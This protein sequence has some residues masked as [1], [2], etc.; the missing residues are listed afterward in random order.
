[1]IEDG[2]TCVIMDGQDV[3]MEEQDEELHNFDTYNATEQNDNHLIWYDWLAD[4]ATTS[5]VTHQW[6]AFTLYTLRVEH[7]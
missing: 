5:H 1:M 4:S 6:E 2:I 7:P 3:I